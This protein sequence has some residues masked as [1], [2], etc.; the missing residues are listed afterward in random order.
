MYELQIVKTK[1]HKPDKKTNDYYI[2][3]LKHVLPLVKDIIDHKQEHAITISMDRDHKVIKTRV[4]HIGT[5]TT[6]AVNIKDLFRGPM[7]DSAE[8]VIFLHNHPGYGSLA[9]SKPDRKFTR[10][11]VKA[12]RILGILVIDSI[13]VSKSGMYSMSKE[14][15]IK[16]KKGDEY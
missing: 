13:I 8:C 6:C 4:V 10:R 9:S 11:M 14:K 5:G 2:T 7:E 16:F 1:T 12:G 15:T 3:K